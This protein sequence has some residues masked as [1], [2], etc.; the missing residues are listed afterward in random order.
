MAAW[1]DE[2]IFEIEIIFNIKSQR[3][4]TEHF[5]SKYLKKCTEYYSLKIYTFRY[6]SSS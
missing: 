3:E 1:E 6:D 5:A 4:W 2:N